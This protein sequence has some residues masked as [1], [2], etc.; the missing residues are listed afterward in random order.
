MIFQLEIILILYNYGLYNKTQTHSQHGDHI[1]LHLF[2]QN[3]ESRLKIKIIM[4]YCNI[5]Y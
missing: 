4:L 5:Q 2:F 3:K 1:K